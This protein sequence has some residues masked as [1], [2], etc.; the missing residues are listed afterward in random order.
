M[1]T[2]EKKIVDPDLEMQCWAVE[3]T[4]EKILDRLPRELWLGYHA[5]L[6]YEIEYKLRLRERIR[7]R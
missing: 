2:T 6:G 3:E 5:I 7:S 4:F 1:N